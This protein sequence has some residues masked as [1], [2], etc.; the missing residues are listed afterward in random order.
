MPLEPPLQTTPNPEDAKYKLDRTKD[1]EPFAD[2]HPDD[3]IVVS[4]VSRISHPT[5]L[6]LF[7]SYGLDWGG[8]EHC[9]AAF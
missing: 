6:I 9:A 3:L 7:K 1:D 8:K 5:I 4:V 2:A